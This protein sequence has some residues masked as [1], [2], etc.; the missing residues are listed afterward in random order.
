VRACV[1]VCVCVCLFVCVC[2][3]VCERER[4]RESV[5]MYSQSY[6]YSGKTNDP[7]GV[8]RSLRSLE[9]HLKQNVEAKVRAATM[10]DEV[11]AGDEG[12]ATLN[13]SRPG[14]RG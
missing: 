8:S 11:D 1:R 6:I 2:V 9:S 13:D 14:S 7:F 5:C 3:C 4:E 10:R 12:A